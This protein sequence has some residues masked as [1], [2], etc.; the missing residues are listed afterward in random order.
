MIWES[1][2]WKADL[3]RA[4]RRLR[5]KKA[6]DSLSDATYARVEKDVMIG[7]FAIRK[8]THAHKLSDSVSKQNV[9]LSAFK[10]AGT[11]ITFLNSHHLDRHYNLGKRAR[12]SLTLPFICNQIIHSYI[13]SLE[14]SANGA[15]RGI[16][17]SSDLERSKMLYR[18]PIGTVIRIFEEVG[19]DYPA[20]VHMTFDEKKGDYAVKQERSH[21]WRG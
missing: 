21:T 2:Y 13:F 1:R 16:F 11:R 17:F 8:L 9:A 14:V 19:V 12:V 5:Q 10:S 15:L 18:L 7:F 6:Q 4:A 3:I 20:Y